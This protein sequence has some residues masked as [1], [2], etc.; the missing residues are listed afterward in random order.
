M[1]A[2]QRFYYIILCLNCRCTH[3]ECVEGAAAGKERESGRVRALLL[4]TITRHNS[5]YINLECCSDYVLF[6]FDHR[7]LCR[8]HHRRVFG[9]RSRSTSQQTHTH[10]YISRS[11]AST[12]QVSP[13][14]IF[15]SEDD[16]L[17]SNRLF[18][19]F[20]LFQ[21]K[22]IIVSK[23]KPHFN[24]GCSPSDDTQ[25]TE[26][27][28]KKTILVYTNLL[29]RC[30]CVGP[31]IV[32]FKNFK[33]KKIGPTFS[34]HSR[35][36]DRISMCVCARAQSTG[37]Q[38]QTHTYTRGHIQAA[39]IHVNSFLCLSPSSSSYSSSLFVLECIFV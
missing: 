27:T 32:P 14:G 30:V 18:F 29:G 3:I 34:M 13:T 23:R 38:T 16:R 19:C 21:P 37:T 33:Y 26:Y 8:Q 1:D 24:D 12:A 2:K 22:L 15:R 35:Y 28:K 5:Q 25:G 4:Y 39:W 10:T 17:K 20:V 11:S 31:C 7:C 36:L 9:I 6:M